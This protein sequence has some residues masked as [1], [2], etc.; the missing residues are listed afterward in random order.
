MHN[1]FAAIWGGSRTIIDGAMPYD[2]AAFAATITRY[3]TEHPPGYNFYTYPGW[4][5][6]AFI[7]LGL[8][9]VPI[10]SGIWTIGG[11]F[12]AVLA[13][14]LLLGRYCPNVPV[15]HTLAGL[16]LLASQPGRL[17]VLVGQ[18]GFVLLA[19]SAAAVVWLSAGRAARAGGIA[20]FFLAKPQLLVAAAF[21]LTVAA[22]AR[23]HGRR[24]LLASV[25]IATL[26]TAVSLIVVPGWPAAWR[27]T[28]PGVLLPDPPQTTTTFT[29]LYSV[30]GR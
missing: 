22:I 8:L 29:L 7:P 30:F 9:S 20:S 28:V 14:R 18:W 21:G 26:A 1:D 27:S 17:T 3:G 5:A 2:P 11:I 23:G 13:L 16:S 10:G 6:V 19:A 12:A 25:G 4:I 15:I 24:F